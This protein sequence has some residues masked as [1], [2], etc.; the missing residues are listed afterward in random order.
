MFSD[1]DRTLFAGRYIYQRLSVGADN[2]SG[3][4]FP[5]P[6]PENCEVEAIAVVEIN[7]SGTVGATAAL[8]RGSTTLISA[9]EAVDQTN[10]VVTAVQG[11]IP[12]FKDEMLQL[13]ITSAAADSRANVAAIVKFNPNP[14]DQ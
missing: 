11:A 5:V 6:V 1:T 7:A 10:V 13:V 8:K 14:S 4:V 9:T 2:S 12:V 3:T